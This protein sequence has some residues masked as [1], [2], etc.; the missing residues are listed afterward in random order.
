MPRYIKYCPICGTEFLAERIGATYC[1]KKCRNRAAKIP[2]DM[3]DILIKG[4]QSRM[5]VL[6]TMPKIVR[7]YIKK[8]SNIA[9]ALKNGG[10]NNSNANASLA[11]RNRNDIPIVLKE[12]EQLRK[13]RETDN[14]EQEFNK[15]ER[16]TQTKTEKRKIH[17]QGNEIEVDIDPEMVDFNKNLDK[18]KGSLKPIGNVDISGNAKYINTEEFPVVGTNGKN[19]SKNG[20]KIKR[21][22]E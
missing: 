9:Q 16:Q 3:L 19:G 6:E 10:V 8:E 14:L 12:I 15:E 11:F 5:S 1:Q 22:G 21:L 13:Q 20:S 2:S 7:D 4:A 18:I 17:V